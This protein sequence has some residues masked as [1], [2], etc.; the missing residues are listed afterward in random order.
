[1]SFPSEMIRT[2]TNI[3]GQ[4]M[5][6]M[7]HSFPGEIIRTSD[8]AIM[9]YRFEKVLLRTNPMYRIGLTRLT[10]MA[11]TLTALPTMFVEGAKALYNVTED[12][13]Q[14]IRR[15]VPDWS[16]NSTIIPIRDEKTGELKYVDFSHGFAYD[17]IGR[18]FRTM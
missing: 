4:A 5:K 14:A 12:E 2:T 6:E 11:F 7:R 10:G 17:L 8:I 16:R 3:G 9:S 15:F 13:I 18:P 1:M